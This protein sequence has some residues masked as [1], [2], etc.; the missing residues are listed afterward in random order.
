M[1]S[2]FQIMSFLLP[3]G[4]EMPG[5]DQK[6]CASLRCSMGIES[7]CVCLSE[8]SQQDLLLVKV[9]VWC[10]NAVLKCFLL[11]P[12]FLETLLLSR[13]PVTFSP[14]RNDRLRYLSCSPSVI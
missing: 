11:I 7:D 9:L 14:H 13:P 4:L 2:R 8:Y 1:L 3:V 12:S 5:L 6:S 10:L